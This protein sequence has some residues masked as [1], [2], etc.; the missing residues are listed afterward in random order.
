[1][2]SL[3]REGAGAVLITGADEAESGHVLNTLYQ[4][5]EIHH[6]KW[7]RLSGSYH[8]SG[9]TLTSSLAARLAL[10]EELVSACQQA[11]QYT[12]DSIRNASNP[13]QG[14]YLPRRIAI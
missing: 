7:P 8:G 12:F 9:C 13:G 14:Q 5:E 6:W 2:R 3:L 4:D 1:A 10:G 11:Q